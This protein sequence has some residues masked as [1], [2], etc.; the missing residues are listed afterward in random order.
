MFKEGVLSERCSVRD[1]ISFLIPLPIR[2]G[3]FKGVKGV[4]IVPANRGQSQDTAR[5]ISLMLCQLRYGSIALGEHC[6]LVS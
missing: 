3:G 2:L 4:C 6:D 5:Y 1:P